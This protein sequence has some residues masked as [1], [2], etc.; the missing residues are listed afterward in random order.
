M[1]DSFVK[2][3]EALAKLISAFAWPAVGI[4]LVWRFTPTLKDFL[5]DMSEGT[6]DQNW[7]KTSRESAV[8]LVLPRKRLTC[9]F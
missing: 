4:Y 7:T 6:L 2:I 5:A 3:V 9:S 1:V 8:L